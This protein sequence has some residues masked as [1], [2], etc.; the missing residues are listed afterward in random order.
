[1]R[2][3]VIDLA[4]IRHNHQTIRARVAPAM[5][6]GVVKANGYGHGIV[7]VARVLEREGIVMNQKKL[8]RRRRPARPCARASG[9][10][11]HRASGRRRGRTESSA[12]CL[13]RECG[14]PGIR[15]AGSDRLRTNAPA[16]RERTD[17]RLPMCAVR[18]PAS[19]LSLRGA[20]RLANPPIAVAALVPQR[21]P[22]GNGLFCEACG[23]KNHE[24]NCQIASGTMG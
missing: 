12:W 8:R 1:M 20:V 16:R 19:P 23:D 6:M 5:V 10:G 21:R 18:P 9:A 24:P 4:A 7:E 22:Y 14:G 13:R 3:L 15:G 2:E 11:R 17:R